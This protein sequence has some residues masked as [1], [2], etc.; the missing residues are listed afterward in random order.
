MMNSLR[1]VLWCLV[2]LGASG[3]ALGYVFQDRFSGS[4]TAAPIKIGGPFEMVNQSGR[5]VTDNGEPV[6]GAP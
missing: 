3:L 4:V 2:A 6:I 5:A 1:I